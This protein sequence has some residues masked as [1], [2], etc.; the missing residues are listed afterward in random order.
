MP[1]PVCVG[2]PASSE[3]AAPLERITIGGAIRINL[4]KMG[5]AAAIQEG[6]YEEE[7]LAVELDFSQPNVDGVMDGVLSGKTTFGFTGPAVMRR[8]MEGDPIMA[9][10]T[11]YQAANIGLMILAD[12]G[13]QSPA[14]LDGKRVIMG[15]GEGSLELR[16]MLLNAGA[17]VE[18]LPFVSTVA[19]LRRM[20]RGEADAVMT[21]LNPT[22]RRAAERGGQA[23]KIMKPSDYG[24]VFYW[25]VI[26]AHADTVRQRPDLIERFDRATQKGVR[27]ALAY[28]ISSLEKYIAQNATNTKQRDRMWS[29]LS[30]QMTTSLS[31]IDKPGAMGMNPE[32]WRHVAQTYAALGDMDPVESMEEF[33]WTPPDSEPI[34]KRMRGLLL[35]LVALLGVIFWNWQL[36][37]SVERQTAELSASHRHQALMLRELNHRVKNNLAGVISLLNQTMRSDASIEEFS[38]TLKGRIT[39]MAT[40]HEMLANSSW[41]EFKIHEAVEKILSFE[42]RVRAER[43][44]LDGPDVNFPS[45]SAVPLCLSLHE[46]YTNATKHGSLSVPGGCV[47]VTWELDNHRMLVF[48]WIESSGPTVSLPAHIGVGTALIEGFIEYELR[49]RVQID[50][51]PGGLR[52]TFQIPL[53]ADSEDFEHRDEPGVH[54]MTV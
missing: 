13:I 8:F 44:K 19:G 49:G 52:C 46:L 24:V 42:F 41:D 3:M 37:R 31:S 10:S 21:A 38:Q 7:G 14:D 29:Y 36:H 16:A 9:V 17:T 22:M 35:V 45:H 30:I 48:R 18:Q 32:R 40:T 27:Y 25:S 5:V 53:A 50:Y 20:K 23:V 1:A 54:A 12:S 34:L 39:A 11:T 6:F 15:N 4:G 47:G 43:V 2:A 26:A 28:P 51:A 33:L